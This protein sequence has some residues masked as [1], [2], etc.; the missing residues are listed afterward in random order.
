MWTR[1]QPRFQA[2]WQ[3]L[4]IAYDDFIRTTEPRHVRV[5]EHVLQALWERGEI[6][7]GE[8]QGW[9]CVPDERFW[10]EKD[11]VDGRC[12]RTAAGRW[13]S[14]AETNYFFRM[15]N[16]Q[17]WLVDYIQTHPDFIQP[18]SPPQRGAGVPAPAAERPVHLAP[19]SAA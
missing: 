15:S 8:Y 7:R 2:A 17:D 9:Y 12:A 4:D 13:S 14:I 5:V 10:T 3:D 19:A 1:W 11:L 16:Y 6:Y 18:D